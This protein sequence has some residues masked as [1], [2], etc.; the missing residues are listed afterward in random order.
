MPEGFYS[1]FTEDP[2]FLKIIKIYHLKIITFNSEKEIITAW[3][4]Q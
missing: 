4:N 2:F 1:D 3:K